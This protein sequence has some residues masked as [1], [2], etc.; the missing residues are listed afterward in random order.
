MTSPPSLIDTLSLDDLSFSNDFDSTLMSRP[1]TTFDSTAL[2]HHVRND[3]S[4]LICR[5]H[6]HVGGACATLGTVLS[7]YQP[8]ST[9]APPGLTLSFALASVCYLY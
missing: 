4:C 3:L 7:C 6:G 1:Y 5:I 8:S 2:L 9:S